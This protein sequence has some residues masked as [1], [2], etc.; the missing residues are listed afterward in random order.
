[1]AVTEERPLELEASEAPEVVEEPMGVFTRPRGGRGWRSWVTTVD[2]KKIGVMYGAV[3]LFFLVVGGVEG[4]LIRVQL[5]TPSS[6]PDELLMS[7]ETYNQMFTMHAVTMIFL[8][9][10]P[11]AA[12]FANYLLPLQ[13]GARDVAFPRL[14][15]LSFWL[16]LFGG[17][18]LNSSWLLGG[19]PDGGWFMYAPNS[20]VVFSPS[21]GVDFF[22]LGLII[23]GVAS[24]ISAI[25]L[26]I[27]VINMRAPGMTLMK[28]PM[29]TW[30]VLVTQL[31]LIFALPVITVALFLLMFDRLFGANF[32]NPSAGG[33]ALL[34]EHLFWIFGHPEVYIIVLPAFGIVSEVVPTFSRKPI[35]GYPF[36]VF[37]G[38][39]IGFMGWGVWAHHMF[40]S[41]IGPVSVAAFSF[42]TMFIA[43]PTGVKILNWLA[44]MY[45]G[46]L[47]F[48]T[49]ML[50]AIGLV[51]MFTIGGLSGVTHSIAPADTQQTDTYYIVGHFHYVLFGGGVMGLFA[52]L[53]FWWPKVFGYKL[54]EAW[55]KWN[56]WVM[57]IG[58]NLTFGPMHILGLQGMSRRIA[59]Y[60]EGYGFNFWNMVATI[61]SFILAVGVLL[62]FINIWVSALRQRRH[63]VDVG[64][65]PWD[66]RSL[67][68]MIPSPP[69][70]HNFDEIPTVTELDEFWYR[71]YGHDE[72]GRLV[73]IAKTED[74]VQKGD[75]AGV[76]LPSPSYWP[77]VLAF[78]LPWIAY[79]LIFNLWFAVFGAACVIAG[80]FGWAMEPP[81]DPEAHRH[82]AGPEADAPEGKSADVEGEGAPVG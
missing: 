82:P 73:R 11:L 32:F 47:R 30:M 34:W 64:P 58:F 66:A 36:M 18:F 3:A 78:G 56:F 5:A 17:L 50:F 45:G 25:N 54:S 35:F 23:A 68:W 19:G 40:A 61:G 46:R 24:L 31:L 71:K 72:Q 1:M 29:F 63:P 10:M 81:D 76:H 14:N 27:T 44:T 39:A 51:A 74:V 22:A 2:H 69:P 41:G 6:S 21:H 15:A 59:T 37:S 8:V 65:D 77:I 52:G 53:Y 13:I 26:A 55:G 57:L 28:M 70:E 75:R 7:A 79:G 43:V 62:F 49:P 67:E 38:I 48:T 20:S 42:A 60:S 4:L 80:A 12:A 16:F 9:V 33:D